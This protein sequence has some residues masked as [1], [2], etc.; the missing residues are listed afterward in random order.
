MPAKRER[1]NTPS[2]SSSSLSDKDVKLMMDGQIKKKKKMPP[3]SPKKTKT[4]WTAA[5]E[6]TFKEGINVV[7][8][9]HLWTELKNDP[10]M[11]QRG[12]NGIAQHWIALYKRM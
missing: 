9:R 4:S 1:E 7:V 12:A 5:E 10:Q 6:A 11:A 8:K 2:S 3:S